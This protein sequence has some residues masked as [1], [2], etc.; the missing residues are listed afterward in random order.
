LTETPKEH[1]VLY[2]TPTRCPF[3]LGPKQFLG[4]SLLN[5]RF[6]TIKQA[7]KQAVVQDEKQTEMPHDS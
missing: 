2:F 4:G 7:S 1:D 5:K 6:K 3:L